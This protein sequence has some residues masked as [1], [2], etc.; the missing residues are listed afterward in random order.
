MLVTSN[1]SF[2][3]S[4]FKRLVSQGRVVGNGLIVVSI[5]LRQSI[6]LAILRSQVRFPEAGVNFG[7]FIGPHIR[8]KHWGSFQE[9]ESREIS[10]SCKNLFLNRCKINT[11]NPLLHRDSFRRIKTRQLLKTLWQKE[12]LLVTS[13]FSFSHNVFYSIRYLYLHLSTFLTYLYLLLNWK[14]LKLAYQVNG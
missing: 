5:V 12:K 6:S 10:R 2:S 1:F 3:H 14:S 7:I 4:V 11:F 9:A 8:R 13:N